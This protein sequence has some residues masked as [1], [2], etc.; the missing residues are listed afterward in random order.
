MESHYRENNLKYNCSQCGASYARAF[1][2]RDHIRAHHP[3]TSDEKADLSVNETI[4]DFEMTEVINASNTILPVD[5][6]GNVLVQLENGTVEKVELVE[7][8]VEEQEVM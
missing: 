3:G 7:Q 6:D 2:L 5:E 4:Q 1:A 8:I